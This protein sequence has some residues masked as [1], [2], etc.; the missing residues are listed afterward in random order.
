MAKTSFIHIRIDED[1]KQTIE[2]AA[3][4]QGKSLT[5]FVVDAAVK[6]ANRVPEDRERSKRRFQGVPTYFR[7]CCMEATRGGE[8]GYGHPAYH[9]SIHLCTEVPWAADFDGWSDEIQRLLEHL[10]NRD[11]EGVWEWF[12]EHFPSWMKLVPRRR[13]SQF[14]HG[15]HLAYEEDRIS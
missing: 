7:A 14:V 13:W 1:A 5:T 2:E 10:A 12:I 3:R 4:R 15:V 9:L 11:D 6:A 8:L